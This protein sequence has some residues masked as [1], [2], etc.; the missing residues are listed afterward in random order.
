M[1]TV[2]VPTV[3][4][5]LGLKQFPLNNEIYCDPVVRHYRGGQPGRDLLNDNPILHIENIAFWAKQLVNKSEDDL[6][7]AP[8][9]SFMGSIKDDLADIG[10]NIVPD[11]TVEYRGDAA[12]FIRQLNSIPAPEGSSRAI[13]VR[14][15]MAYFWPKSL[16][17]A[18]AAEGYKVILDELI[19]S[20]VSHLFA[21]FTWCSFVGVSTDLFVV[22]S[23][24]YNAHPILNT[25]TVEAQND[26]L[27]FSWIG[28]QII[29]YPLHFWHYQLT[30]LENH[31]TTVHWD[32]NV[33]HDKKVLFLNRQPRPHRLFA[34]SYFQQRNFLDEM[35]WSMLMP[36]NVVTDTDDQYFDLL[37]EGVNQ[38][39]HHY[40][41]VPHWFTETAI[42]QLQSIVP[43]KLDQPP[44][45]MLGIID[46]Y[47][48]ENSALSLVSETI[49]GRYPIYDMGTNEFPVFSPWIMNFYTNQHFRNT[50]R[51][52]GFITEKTFK[53]I[54]MGHP[55]TVI[56]NNKT[57]EM[58]RLFGF[59]TFQHAG[60]DESYDLEVDD[61]KRLQMVLD[62]TLRVSKEGFH[63]RAASEIVRHNKEL[64]FNKQHLIRLC[65]K[66]LV[67]PL[68]EAC[69]QPKKIVRHLGTSFPG[70]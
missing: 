11:S 21:F 57:L 20:H 49:G 38:P 66:W 22:L 51:R 55:F 59:R 12:D 14:S 18:L 13:C 70:D 65:K 50:H 1:L 67:D 62:E 46:K 44:A 56:G 19:E 26:D 60:I 10:L 45:G 8:F 3:I 69:T 5:Q 24:R 30:L 23:S 39:G 68:T 33:K 35:F 28:V 53:P 64:F 42:R 37:V 25:K 41:N 29:N 40:N 7:A 9:H 15:P 43:R 17:D 4:R 47:Y 27:D 61:H 34:L 2:I 52:Y 32:W 48:I 58:L 54:S 31:P 36:D 16:Y 6:I 63:R